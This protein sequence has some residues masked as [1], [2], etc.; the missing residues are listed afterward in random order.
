VVLGLITAEE[1]AAVILDDLVEQPA[2]GHAALGGQCAEDGV[3]GRA[4]PGV[5]PPAE[6]GGYDPVPVTAAVILD[7]PVEDGLHGHAAL[8]GQRAERGVGGFGDADGEGVHAPY[9][10]QWNVQAGTRLFSRDCQ[11]LGVPGGPPVGSQVQPATERIPA[12]LLGM[13][14]A[15]ASSGG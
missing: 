13:L 8:G 11:P 2:D 6:V 10:G 3:R 1:P 14:L 4:N 15:L 5:G 12:A 9:H 7:G